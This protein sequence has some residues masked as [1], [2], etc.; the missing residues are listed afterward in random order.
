M[1][2]GTEKAQIAREGLCSSSEYIY[3]LQIGYCD[4][5]DDTQASAKYAPLG[6]V[7]LSLYGVVCV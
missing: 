7:L 6:D 1:K 4:H 3:V 5:G 2:R